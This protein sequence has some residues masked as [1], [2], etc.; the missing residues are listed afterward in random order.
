MSDGIKNE[1]VPSFPDRFAES[2]KIVDYGLGLVAE[3]RLKNPINVGSYDPVTNPHG[4][5]A[6]CLH[7]SFGPDELESL[8]DDPE[9]PYSAQDR[10]FMKNALYELDQI[11][12]PTP[13]EPS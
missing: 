2:A 3:F 11:H 12:Q 10:Q 9:A 4:T 1:Q 7:T 8:L 6:A 13:D 5:F